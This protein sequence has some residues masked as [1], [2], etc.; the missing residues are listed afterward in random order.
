[1]WQKLAVVDPEVSKVVEASLVKVINASGALW[2][3]STK[4]TSK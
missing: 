2:V 4:K 3:E 1:M